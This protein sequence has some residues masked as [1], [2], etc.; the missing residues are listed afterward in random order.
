MPGEDDV[1]DPFGAVAL[2]PV[3]DFC[4]TCPESG[5]DAVVNALG[6]VAGQRLAHALADQLVGSLNGLVLRTAG[7]Q[8]AAV[9]READPEAGNR[10]HKPFGPARVCYCLRR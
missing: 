4:V 1:E 7:S 10:A 2:Q 5:R 3:F 9:G 6:D 8:I